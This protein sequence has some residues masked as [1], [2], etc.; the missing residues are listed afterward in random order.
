MQNLLNLFA[1]EPAMVVGTVNAVLVLLVTFGLPI[2]EDQKAAIDGVLFA[3]L[4]IVAA[5]T[6]RSQVT[7]V[8]R[9]TGAALP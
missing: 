7:P 3:L 5:V 9:P 6:I 1:R 4:A 8:A 2:G